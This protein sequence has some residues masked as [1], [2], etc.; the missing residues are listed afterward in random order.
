MIDGETVRRL[1]LG[2]LEE[3][4]SGHQR[5]GRQEEILVDLDL[6]VVGDVDVDQ[7]ADTVA[8]QRLE[9]ERADA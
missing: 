7:H 2:E 1:L 6:E 8:L 4:A 9:H 5:D 3:F